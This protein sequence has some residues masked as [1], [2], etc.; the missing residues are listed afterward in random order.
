MSIWTLKGRLPGGPGGVGDGDGRASFLPTV[1][2]GVALSAVAS[3][4]IGSTPSVGAALS[5]VARALV[6][7]TAGVEVAASVSGSLR[8]EEVETGVELDVVAVNPTGARTESGAEIVQITYAATR[9]RGGVTLTNLGGNAMTNPNNALGLR[10]G[11]TATGAGNVLGARTYS[12]ELSNYSVVPLDGFTFLGAELHY[13]LN[14]SGTALNN[15]GLTVGY[16]T[17]LAPYVQAA[18]FAGNVDY[19]TDPYVVDLGTSV[20]WA[21][22]G[23]IKTRAGTSTSALNTSAIAIDAIEIVVY[24]TRTD[25]L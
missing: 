21:S 2:P 5:A 14:Q 12:I 9:R 13:Y 6:P 8:T 11:T 24:A 17:A 3:L 23:G 1:R 25:A 19:L 18:A 20:P 7:T 10:N 4:L 22:L 15:G 16:T